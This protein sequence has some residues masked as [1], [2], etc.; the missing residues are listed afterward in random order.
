MDIQVGNLVI[1][2]DEASSNIIYGA[3]DKICEDEDFCI[4]LQ[5]QNNFC[6]K[7]E[8]PFQRVPKNRLLVL[9]PNIFEVI[10]NLFLNFE[11]DVESMGEFKALAEA[12]RAN[13]KMYPALPPNFAEEGA[14]ADL[15][16][17]KLFLLFV[18]GRGGE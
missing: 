15:N 6:K 10:E 14:P 2:S 16:V 7:I 4:L 11:A 5:F 9:T 18:G 1:Y 17:N 8:E 12:F 3:V 13:T